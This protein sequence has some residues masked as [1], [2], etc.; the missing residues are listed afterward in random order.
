MGRVSWQSCQSIVHTSKPKHKYLIL[1]YLTSMHTRSKYLTVNP[2]LAVSERYVVLSP[3]LNNIARHRLVENTPHGLFFDADSLSRMNRIPSINR[4]CA[5]ANLQIMGWL[6]KK[7][8]ARSAS[9]RR[10][11]VDVGKLPT[12]SFVQTTPGESSRS[13]TA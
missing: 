9:Q 4:W 13:T 7:G 3:C 1:R 8:D 6:K 2:Y 10:T 11:R 5:D 12:D